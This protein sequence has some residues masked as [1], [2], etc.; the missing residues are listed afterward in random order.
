MVNMTVNQDT[1]AKAVRTLT[2]NGLSYT[3]CGLEG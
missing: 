1:V 3:N 2:N